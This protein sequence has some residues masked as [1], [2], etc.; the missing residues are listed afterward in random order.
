MNLS[1]PVLSLIPVLAGP[2]LTVLAGTTRPLTGREVQR[3]L[4][5]SASQPG[6]QA[7]LSELAA[8]GLVL[9]TPSGNAILHELNRDHLLAPLIGQL[10]SLRAAVFTAVADVIRSQAPG[11][12][13]AVLFGSVARGDADHTSDLDLAL[14][15]PDDADEDTRET[16]AADI[17][18]AIRRL[19]GN[20][21]TPLQFTESEF[22]DLPERA[23]QLHAE[24][25]S[26][27]VDLVVRDAASP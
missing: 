5:M 6:V 25:R 8:H 12:S 18:R 16:A 20:A 9:Q 19:T 21:C 15:W 1:Q 26:D 10:P 3:L 23:P 4:P 7:A 22:A 2:V 24:L 13:R 17:G 14:V 11:A 27:G